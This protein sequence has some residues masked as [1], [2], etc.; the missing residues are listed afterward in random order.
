[1]RPLNRLKVRGIRTLGLTSMSTPLAVWMYT[2]NRPDLFK[3]ESSR[4]RRH[5]VVSSV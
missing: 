3:G 5:W 2:C 4:V 1:M